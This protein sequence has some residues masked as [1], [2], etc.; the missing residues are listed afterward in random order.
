MLFRS[1][2][3]PKPAAVLNT[4]YVERN[5]QFSPDGH[6]IAYVSE[7]SGR[8]EVYVQSF[9]PAGGGFKG[10]ISVAGGDQPRWRGKELFFLAP[11]GTVMAVGISIAGGKIV[12]GNP[13]SLFK[14]PVVQKEPV[15]PSTFHWDTADGQKFLI[16]TNAEVAPEPV[17]IVQNWMAG[18]PGK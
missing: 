18:L 10:Q 5:A 14:V 16:G 8:P 9:P 15:G 7:E 3:E 12:T 1:T 17:T 13:A 2:G 6:W 4:Q 11:D